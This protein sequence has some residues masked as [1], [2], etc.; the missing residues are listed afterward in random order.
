MYEKGHYKR[1]HYSGLRAAGILLCF[2]GYNLK[3]KEFYMYVISV[4]VV[5]LIVSFL[6]E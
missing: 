1:D 2:A 3:S 6:A 5:Y 4:I